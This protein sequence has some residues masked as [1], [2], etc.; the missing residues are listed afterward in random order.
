MS[1]KRVEKVKVPHYNRVKPSRAPKNKKE[2]SLAREAGRKMIHLLSLFFILLFWY[3]SSAYGK[4]WALTSLVFLLIIFLEVEFI[5]IELGK[6]IP[7]L[8]LAYREKEKE[9]IAGN[10]FFLISTIIVLA[11]FDLDVAIAAI[12]MTTFGDLAAALIGRR[13]GR[14]WITNHVALEGVLAQFV[15]DLIIGLLV[16]GFAVGGVMAITSTLVESS[17]RKLDDNLVIPI[18]AGFNGQIMRFILNSF[19]P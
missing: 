17:V 1:K 19:T 16:V 10:V 3:L 4:T 7:L 8:H 13:F 18:F 14:T 11:V 9:T 6:K 2:W 15:V 12:L 5:R